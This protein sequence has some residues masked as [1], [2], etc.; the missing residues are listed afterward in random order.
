MMGSL[1]A[2]ARAR[3]SNRDPSARSGAAGDGIGNGRAAAIL[4]ARAGTRVLVVD[5]DGT[6][7]ERTVAMIAA[8]GGTAA[9]YQGD[10][11]DPVQATC[12]PPCSTDLVGSISSTTTWGSAAV[13]RSSTR[14]RKTG[15]CHAGQSRADVPGRQVCHSR[16]DQNGRARCHRQHLFH[17]AVIALTRA[18]AVDH[19]KDGVRVNCVAP[20]PVYTPMVYAGGMSASAR[21]Q[22]RKASALRV[23]AGTGLV[24][25]RRAGEGG[26]MDAEAAHRLVDTYRA[27]LAVGSVTFL[28]VVRG[29]NLRLAADLMV[30]FATG[31]RRRT[32]PSGLTPISFWCR[33]RSSNLA[34]TMAASLLRAFGLRPKRRCARRKRV[35]ARC[36]FPRT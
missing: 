5:R 7:A 4:L 11:T 27:R 3:G 6:L 10:L 21:E 25:A 34:P 32:S 9:A 24:L 13:V 17:R 31:L 19:A 12:W 35:C 15:A 28:D 30:P 23:R 20:G 36:C 26:L 33:R 1:A 14:P 22:R 18:M 29:E 8:E 2:S 16:H